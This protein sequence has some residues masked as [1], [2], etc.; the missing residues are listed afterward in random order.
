[1]GCWRRTVFD[2]A[3]NDDQTLM[4]RVQAGEVDTVL[5]VFPDL[6]GRLM[7]KRLTAPFFLNEVARAGIYVLACEAFGSDGVRVGVEKVVVGC[8]NRSQ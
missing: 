8:A 4:L 1:M 2:L 3:S 6:Q 5:V 7:G